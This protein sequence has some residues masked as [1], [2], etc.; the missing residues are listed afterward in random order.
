MCAPHTTL[1]PLPIGID[2][3]VRYLQNAP[4]ITLHTPR[5]AGC[6]GGV[7][8]FDPV[9]RVLAQS[10]PLLHLEC[11]H[12]LKSRGRGAATNLPQVHGFGA[13]RADGITSG[14]FA[15]K[16]LRRIQ[17]Q[18]GCF[19]SSCALKAAVISALQTWRSKCRVRKY[20]LRMLSASLSN[21]SWAL[22]R[23]D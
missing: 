10:R 3:G 5:T 23:S 8:F 16:A 19:L 2:A 21:I 20:P 4:H 11:C 22:G 18:F 14:C 12:A 6:T 15:S 1:H 13:R 17:W 7:Y 9:E